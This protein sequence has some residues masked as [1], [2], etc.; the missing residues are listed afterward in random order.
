VNDDLTQVTLNFDVSGLGSTTNDSAIVEVV[1]AQ[2]W[3]NNGLNQTATTTFAIDTELSSPSIGTVGDT[4]NQ[5]NTEDNV[6]SG[7]VNFTEDSSPSPDDDVVSTNYYLLKGA[8]GDYDPSSDRDNLTELETPSHTN[9]EELSDGRHTFVVYSTDDAGNEEFATQKVTIDNWDVVSE[10]TGQEPLTGEVDISEAFTVYNTG[11]EDPVYYYAKDDG[12][13]DPTTKDGYTQA[14]SFSVDEDGTYYLAAEVPDPGYDGDPNTVFQHTGGIEGQALDASLSVDVN[15]GTGVSTQSHAGTFTVNVTSDM[16]LDSLHV[17]AFQDDAYLYQGEAHFGLDDFEQVDVDDGYKYTLTIGPVR[18]GAYDFALKGA[19]SDNLELGGSQWVNDTQMDAT[20]PV[21]MDA[22]V[23]DGGQDQL[24]VN[25]TFDEPVDETTV[26]ASDFAVDGVDTSA[27]SVTGTGDQGYVEVAFDSEFQSGDGPQLTVADGSVVEALGS[28][29]NSESA[30]EIDTIEL[31]LDAGRN[32]VSI[33]SEA[34]TVDLDSALG[35]GTA[36][37]VANSI[38]SIWQYEDGEW[39]SYDPNADDNDFSTLKGGEGYVVVTNYA[40]E[41]DV[42]AYNVVNS[43]AD[44]GPTAPT[45]ERVEAGWNLVGHFQEGDQTTDRALKTINRT[46][47]VSNNVVRVLGSTGG[48]NFADTDTMSAG[49][50]Y[51]VFVEDSDQYTAMNYED[52]DT[53]AP[54]IY[55]ATV[56]DAT[57]GDDTVTEGDDVLIEADVGGDVDAVHA[58]ASAI[59]GDSSLALTDGDGDGV[60]DA[61][62]TG[63]SAAESGVKDVVVTASNMDGLQA[64]DSDT[65]TYDNDLSTLSIDS[66]ADGATIEDTSTE[67]INVTVSDEFSDI[68]DLKVMLNNSAGQSYDGSAFSDAKTFIINETGAATYSVDLPNLDDGDYIVVANATDSEGNEAGVTS[69]FTVDQVKPSA[70]FD[71]Q[72]FTASGTSYDL[73]QHTTVSGEDSTTYEYSNDSGANWNAI[74]DPTAWNTTQES[75]GNVTVRVTADDNQGNSDSDTANAT[76]D[77]TA[78][79]M[80]S[81][82]GSTGQKEVTL[83]FDEGVYANADGTGDLTATQFNYVDNSA[84]GA[85]SITG[86]THNASENTVTLTLDANIQSSDQDS[87]VIEIATG[88]SVYDEVGNERTTDSATLT[89]P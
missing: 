39:Q 70:T 1:D 9:T 2:D 37:H 54:E 12:T 52:G 40:V 82:T 67:S 41:W 45:A 57:D 6:V 3:V 74:T 36:S 63:V 13:F 22:D 87:D 81:A 11:T 21:L 47:D 8:N 27:I 66:P 72:N 34:G 68:S 30:A 75:D 51:W 58:D 77:N 55:S 24:V 5:A 83:T 20:D 10:F 50:G 89:A 76:I 32:V 53:V 18:D 49:E 19:E 31:D 29:S 23:T 15:E 43:G 60:Y 33:P 56:A 38:E 88:E 26:D 62:V 86:V 73:T 71:D 44:D 28:G 64:T 17:D 16:P 69:E 84:D 42:Q 14:D 78:P 59:G 79:S 35:V 7:Y 65:V 25:A 48:L 85:S 61:T 80:Q 4:D 46:P